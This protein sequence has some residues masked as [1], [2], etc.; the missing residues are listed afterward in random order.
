MM[1][2]KQER[3]ASQARN[4]QEIHI[5]IHPTCDSITDSGPGQSYLKE[6]MWGNCL[7]G[8][9][10]IERKTISASKCGR[11]STGRGKWQASNVGPEKHPA[12]L[13]LTLIQLAL[14]R[15]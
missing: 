8:T 1:L 13:K 12:G 5:R 3:R 2:I 11:G 10:K 7:R 9:E 6:L 14:Y 15:R 4:P